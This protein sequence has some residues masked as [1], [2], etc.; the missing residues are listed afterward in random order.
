MSGFPDPEQ[1]LARGV[2]AQFGEPAHALDLGRIEHEK[3]LRQA[4]VGDMIVQFAQPLAQD[5]DDVVPRGR[6]GVQE[7]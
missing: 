5:A 1:R 6:M 2:V 7:R 4:E 3:E